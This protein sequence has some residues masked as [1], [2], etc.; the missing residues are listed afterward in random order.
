MPSWR[1]LLSAPWSARLHVRGRRS[2]RECRRPSPPRAQ[3]LPPAR[4]SSLSATDTTRPACTADV[5]QTPLHAFA[6]NGARL[7]LSRRSA[8]QRMRASPRARRGSRGRPAT[9][10]GPQPGGAVSA[11]GVA[12]G[13]GPS[14]RAAAPAVAPAVVRVVCCH[15]LQSYPYSSNARSLAPAISRLTVRSYE[16][17]PARPH[18]L[19]A[20]GS[21][22]P[23]LRAT[24]GGPAEHSGTTT[25]RSPRTAGSPTFRRSSGPTGPL[26]GLW[27][28]TRRSPPEGRPGYPLFFFNSCGRLST[29]RQSYSGPPSPSRGEVPTE[30]SRSRPEA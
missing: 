14:R 22:L 20:A 17:S 1:A 24:A 19:R 25:R 16:R 28:G 10:H 23:R 21:H 8:P 6:A 27:R 15:V 5:V 29:L 11:P 30:S 12:A 13:R 2:S 9:A 7:G 3:R 4:S 18:S 26:S